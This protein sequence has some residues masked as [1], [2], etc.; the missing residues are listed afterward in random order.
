M[1]VLLPDVDGRVRVWSLAGAAARC[2]SYMAVCAL[3]LEYDA[4]ANCCRVAALLIPVGCTLCSLGARDRWRLLLPDV[5]RSVRLGGLGSSC[6]CVLLVCVAAAST[7]K[8][9]LEWF[10]AK[11][12]LSGHR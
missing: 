10:D 8:L 7:L 9:E 4:T 2:L 3:E 12:K 6:A 11:L 5:N 1:L